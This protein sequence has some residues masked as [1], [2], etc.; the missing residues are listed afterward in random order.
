MV[1]QWLLTAPLPHFGARRLPTVLFAV[2]CLALQVGISAVGNYGT[3]NVLTAALTVPLLLPF[4][5]SVAPVE[6][7]PSAGLAALPAAVA[8]AAQVAAAL[9]S[10]LGGVAYLPHCSWCSYVRLR[11]WLHMP[12]GARVSCWLLLHTQCFLAMRDQWPCALPLPAPPCT[13]IVLLLA[14]MGP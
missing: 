10:L 12:L 9:L 8:V 1:V 11:H 14:P 5:P 3:F 13:A 2:A 6:E 7:L 4:S